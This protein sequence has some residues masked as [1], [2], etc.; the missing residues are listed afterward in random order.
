MLQDIIKKLS[1]R[2]FLT[3]IAGVVLGICMIF[4]LD[5]GTVS[6]ITGAVMS[7]ASVVSYII[8]EGKIDEAAVPGI[9]DA[10]DKVTDAIDAV[11]NIK[12]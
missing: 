4:G 7:V 11:G 9:K 6:T 10:T 2:K 8:A 1:S 5:Q 12:E 3:C